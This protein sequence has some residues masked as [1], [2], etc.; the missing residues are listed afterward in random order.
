MQYKKVR[1]EKSTE[2]EAVQ[3]KPHQILAEFSIH[4]NFMFLSDTPYI[5]FILQHVANQSEIFRVV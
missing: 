2:N 4:R 3:T 5:P 1:N